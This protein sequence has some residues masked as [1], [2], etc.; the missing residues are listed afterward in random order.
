[1][2]RI[3]KY[4]IVG[5]FIYKNGV[6]ARIIVKNNRDKKTYRLSIPAEKLGQ[7]LDEEQ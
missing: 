1:M 3:P 5:V 4:K 2:Y 7:M 6:S